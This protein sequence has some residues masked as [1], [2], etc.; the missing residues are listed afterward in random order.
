MAEDDI[1]LLAAQGADPPVSMHSCGH[2]LQVRCVM[3]GA[4]IS[5]MICQSAAEPIHC[6]KPLCIKQHAE[7]IAVL[8][9]GTVHTA[10]CCGVGPV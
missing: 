8:G 9:Q 5:V 4:A 6:S 7:R 3:H 2:L 10:A 1:L